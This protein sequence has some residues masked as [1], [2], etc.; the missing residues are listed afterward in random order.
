GKTYI[1]AAYTCT[2]LVA[3][4]VSGLADGQKVVGR[5]VVDLGAGNAPWDIVTYNSGGKDYVLVANR[6]HEM[7]KLSAE[8]LVNAPAL[9]TPDAPNTLTRT[10]VSPKGA[11]VQ[12]SD[13]DAAN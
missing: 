13:Y 6:T 7:M 1:L 9:T 8:E 10:N 2:P 12:L 5:T 4:E 3:F 11:V